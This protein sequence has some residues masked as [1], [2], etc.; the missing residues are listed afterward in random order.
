MATIFIEIGI[1]IIAATLLAY[2]GRFLRQPSIIAYILAG[3]IIGP[4]G[5]QLISSRE[6]INVFSELGIV[7]LLFIVGLQLDFTKLKDVG[8]SS[9]ALG[10]GQVI[11]TA[12]IGYFIAAQWFNH[13]TSLY[14]AVALTFSSTVIVLKLLT[15]KNELHTLHGRIA[16]GVLLFQDLIAIFALVIFSSFSSFSPSV[17]LQITLKIAAFFIAAA[18]A[19]RY[20]IPYAL[21][22]VASSTE[23]LFLASI[24]WGF[25]V[26]LF[27]YSLDFSIAAGVFIAGITMSSNPYATEIGSRIKPLRD[28][29]VT[30]FFVSL[31]MQIAIE[32][33]RQYLIPTVALSLFVLIGN[34]LI[35]LIINAI[36]GYH[37]RTSFLSAVSLAQI[38]EFSLVLVSL[39]FSLGHIP[40]EIVAITATI[41]TIT[42]GISSYFI[43]YDEQLYKIFKPFLR[44]KS[45]E[46]H[47]LYTPEINYDAVLCGYNR[48]GYSI[49]NKLHAI[50][51]K[52]LVVD[53]NPDIVKYLSSKGIP[54]LYGDVSDAEVVEKM[55]LKNVKLLVSTI[56]NMQ[57]D[58][59]ILSKLRQAN[60]DAVAVFTASQIDD[61]LKL[62]NS[63]ADYV[64]LPHLVGGEHFA[65]MIKDFTFKS[66][67]KQKQDHIREL[68]KRKALGHQKEV[69]N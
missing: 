46:Q 50:K 29:F 44:W 67:R 18:V 27:A 39:G 58:L 19:G 21:K 37:P 69:S 30:M 62:Y 7:F 23:L 4:I 13:I 45:K 53:Y 54:C 1:I 40:A 24:S 25:I 43:I 66:L 65:L 34:P 42:I 68:H 32:P 16:L 52:T 60:Q 36:Y 20:L 51:K 8:K 3:I 59:L 14:L 17:L 22:Y 47:D 33:L 63:G 61:A 6:L 12:V 49:L 28:F 57:D 38:S 5:L 11:F 64:I 9:L 31:G 35:M 26:A 10:F 2:L 55:N 41:A 15:D 56:S 48:I